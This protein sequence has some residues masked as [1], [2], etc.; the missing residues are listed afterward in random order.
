MSWTSLCEVDQLQDDRGKY[1]EIDGFQLAVIMHQGQVYV[2][3][4]TC[5]HKGDNLFEGRVERGCVVCPWHAYTFTLETGKNI[6]PSHAGIT[7]YPT[8]MHERRGEPTLVQ[9]DLPIP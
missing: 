7:V 2:L 1:V 8:R 3:D 9:A 6:I 5:P 4:N